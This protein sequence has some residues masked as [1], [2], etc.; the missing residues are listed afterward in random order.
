M[1]PAMHNKTVSKK[2]KSEITRGFHCEQGKAK[3]SEKAKAGL[4]PVWF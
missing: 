2:A 3:E 4:I 1:H